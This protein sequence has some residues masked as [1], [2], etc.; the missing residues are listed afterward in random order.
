MSPDRLQEFMEEKMEEEKAS[1]VATRRLYA[2]PSDDLEPKFF[3][4]GDCVDCGEDLDL[5]R[6]QKGRIRCVGCQTLLERRK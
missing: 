2:I 6:K 5:F 1:I 4:R 3:I